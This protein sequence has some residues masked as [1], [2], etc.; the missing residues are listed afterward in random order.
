MK[1]NKNIFFVFIIQLVFVTSFGQSAKKQEIINKALS[2]ETI[3][4]QFNTL[5]LQ[6]PS[7]QSFKNI[8]QVNLTK[9]TR[10]FK[11]SIIATN[12]K[13]KDAYL[14]IDNQKNEIEKL[15]ATINTVNTDL[16]T[17]S[18]EKDSI[19][20]FGFRMSKATYNTILWSIISA[21]LAT[22]L[23]FLLKYRSSHSITKSAK[24]SLLEIDQEFEEH[25]KKSLEREQVLRRKLQDEIN[26]QRGTK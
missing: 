7:Y 24:T 9:F 14:K 19:G 10:N 12:K 26:K 18:E 17:V 23:F 21:L 2:G 6:S 8:R 4:N 5:I 13:F 3:E 15:K 20:L 11:D 22:T 25:K 16:N 1:L